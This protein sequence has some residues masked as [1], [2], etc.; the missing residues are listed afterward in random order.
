MVGVTGVVGVGVGV[1]VG[2]VEVTGVVGV[3]V[4][5]GLVEVTGVVGVRVVLVGATNGVNG[6]V[7]GGLVET[8]GFVLIIGI[9]VILVVGLGL[10]FMPRV[11]AGG[12]VFPGVGAFP[13]VGAG[14]VFPGVSISFILIGGRP[15]ISRI[16]L[17]I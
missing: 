17:S 7:E 14:V 12:V 10:P 1:G 8:Q 15:N 9:F 2:L 4:G 16:I 6:G 5:V 11:V 13:V 3:R